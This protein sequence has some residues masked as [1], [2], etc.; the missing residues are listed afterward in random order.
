MLHV[1]QLSEEEDVEMSLDN[2]PNE[3]SSAYILSPEEP[4]QHHHT[5]DTQ[6]LEPPKGG[7]MWIGVAQR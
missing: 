6:T 3:Q 4:S 2:Q 5:Y 1:D 7:S